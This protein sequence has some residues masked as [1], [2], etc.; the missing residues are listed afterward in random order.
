MIQH[1]LSVTVTRHV[2]AYRMCLADKGQPP[3][4]L[5]PR[6][7]GQT[8]GMFDFFSNVVVHFLFA[9]FFFFSL[10]TFFLATHFFFVWVL[11]VSKNGIS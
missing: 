3:A 1:V 9:T 2:Q 6:K 4:R 8:N 11:F 5:L 10:L 7:R